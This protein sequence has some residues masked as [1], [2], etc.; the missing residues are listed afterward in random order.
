MP[1]PTPAPDTTD[2]ADAADTTDTSPA[3]PTSAQ[4]DAL[5][6]DLDRIDA[7]LARLDEER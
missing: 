3:L 7:V 5:E 2:T 1:E 4:L 6:D